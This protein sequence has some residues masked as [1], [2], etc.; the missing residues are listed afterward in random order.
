MVSFIQVF[1]FMKK[2]TKKQLIF[3][4]FGVLIAG[5]TANF[6]I[7]GSVGQFLATTGE[8]VFFTALVLLMI[9]F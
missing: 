5:E 3:I 4:A 9:V 2:L 8:I 6:F 7:G 1:M